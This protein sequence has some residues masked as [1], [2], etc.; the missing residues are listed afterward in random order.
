M[1]LIYSTPI[2][3]YTQ[4]AGI[5]TLQHLHLSFSMQTQTSFLNLSSVYIVTDYSVSL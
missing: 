1:E 2:E 5:S 3:T 4:T